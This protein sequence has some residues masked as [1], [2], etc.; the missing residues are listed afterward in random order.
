MFFHNEVREFPFEP[1]C[2]D[3]VVVDPMVVPAP[4]FTENDGVVFKPMALQPLFGNRAMFFG[5]RSEKGNDCLLYTSDAADEGF[6]V[7]LGGP[8]IIKKKKT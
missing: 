8:R 6:G 1:C 7:V 4:G 5:A 2:F 3:N